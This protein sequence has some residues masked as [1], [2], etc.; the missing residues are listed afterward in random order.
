VGGG[1]IIVPVLSLAFAVPHV[2]AKGTSLAVIL[3]TAIMGTIRNRQTQLTALKPAMVVGLAG[4]ASA[5]AA[6]R[7]SL[8]LDPKVSRAL[9]AGLLTF[10]A[11]RLAVTGWAG[12]RATPAPAVAGAQAE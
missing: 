6:S 4:V 5:L 2:L 7:L 8:G 1:I 11:A 12:L 3:P 10:A 9:F